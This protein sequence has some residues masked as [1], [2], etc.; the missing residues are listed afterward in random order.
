[1]KQSRQILVCLGG[2]NK[3][4]LLYRLVY[5][6]QHEFGITTSS[7]M[8]SRRNWSGEGAGSWQKVDSGTKKVSVGQVPFVV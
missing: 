8:T 7:G 2:N 3:F 6:G 4:S 1:M 5:N